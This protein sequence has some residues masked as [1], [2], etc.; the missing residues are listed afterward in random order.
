[1]AIEAANADTL[2]NVKAPY[3][4]H[5]R[6]AVRADIPAITQILT[7][8]LVEFE[9]HDHFCPKRQHHRDGE[10]YAYVLNRVRMFF[11]KP[12]VR[13]MVAE[14]LELG[15]TGPKATV[16]GFAT[17]E[18]QGEK[19]PVAAEWKR[20][21]RGLFNAVEQQLVHFESLH[22]RHARNRIFDYQTFESLIETLHNAYGNIASLE[23]NFHL[24]FLMV[25]PAWQKGYGIGHRL[26]QWGLDISD[27]V[28]LP[29]VLEA[30]LAGYPFYL[31]HNLKLL[32]MV[33]IDAV[34]EKAYDMPV[35]VYE[36]KGKE[37]HFI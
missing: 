24:Q 33:R 13:Y 16:L 17:W 31:R 15:V 35:V 10:F 14:K 3:E 26:L 36:P 7:T 21:D 22:H 37:G 32:T 2:R 1:M 19:N 29:V 30:S 9:F 11:V 27:Q 12:G 6:F 25:D 34:P 23:S 4:I 18:A 8:N 20:Q 28:G 5:L